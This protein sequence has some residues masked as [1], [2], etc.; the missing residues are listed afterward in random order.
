MPSEARSVAA[1]DPAPIPAPDPAP[2]WTPAPTI[3]V[4]RPDAIEPTPEP[5]ELEPQHPTPKPPKSVPPPDPVP[6]KF[7]AGSLRFAYVKVGAKRLLI[8]PTGTV[9]L[10]P[11]THKVYVR[12]DAAADWTYFGKLVLRP[13]DGHRL[14]V[15]E[16]VNPKG[17]A[18]SHV[19]R[20]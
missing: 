3:S 17:L 8:E 7:V 9:E 2:A 13:N 16:L 18:I 11:G 4:A 1:P 20:P 10:P 14:E 15:V 5:A 12:R 6:V 19:T